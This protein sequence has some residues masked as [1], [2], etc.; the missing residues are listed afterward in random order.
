MAD[1]L[2][3]T[4]M[5]LD[6]EVKYAVF[7]GK[8]NS[9][10]G[11]DG[12]NFHFYKSAWQVI[13]LVVIRAV[14]SFFQKCYMP[15][16]VKATALAIVP[17]HK[18]ASNISEYR[19]I[20]LCNVFYKII[21]KVL[22]ER[23]KPV[24]NAIVKDN[25][26]G[27]VK[28][29]VSTD[30]ILL[31]NDI[32]FYAGKK[33]G[34][35]YF[36]A[37]LDIKKA[38]DSVSRDF[39]LERMLQKG[40]PSLF[41]NWIKSCISNVNYSILLNGTLEGYFSSSAGLR[42]GC[43][44]SPYL[45]CIVMDAFSNL[46]EYRGFRG[47]SHKEYSLSHLLY[48]DDVLI[49]GEASSE[50]CNILASILMDFANATGLNINYDKCSIMFPRNLRNAQEVCQ[51]LSIHN[52]VNNITYLGIPLSFYRLKIADF[53]PLMDSVSKK[54]NGWKACLL[55]FAGRMQYIKFT[56]QNTIAYWIRGSIMPKT[57]HKF[58]KR[59]SSKFL[60]F[61]DNMEVK[62][63]HMV[64]WDKICLPKNKGGLGIPSI[65]AL[66]YAY[67]CSV[68]YRMYNVSSPLSNWLLCVYKSPWMAPP[69]AASKIWKSICK[70][71]LAVKHCFTFNITR[72]APISLKYD[73]WCRN[74]TITEFLGGSFQGYCPDITLNTLICGNQWVFPDSI[75]ASL[76]SIIEGF[77]IPATDG[78]CLLWK[79]TNSYKFKSF[80][81][82][83][84]SDYQTCCW[85]KAIWP[86]K[87]ISKH[88]VFA[89]L[90]LVRGL[91]TA[92]ALIYRNINVPARCSLCYAFNE[93]INH[94][95][96]ECDYVFAVLTAVIPGLKSFLFRPSIMQVFEWIKGKHS[97]NKR[98]KHFFYMIICCVIYH[99]WKERNGRRFGNASICHATLSMNV[100]RNISDR[101]IGWKNYWSYLEL[102]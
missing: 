87:C 33:R 92:D 32:L 6:D 64:A 20:A 24:M 26:A 38:F 52:I 95:F 13:A 30:N 102:L 21:A 40:F 49:F 48:A 51:A 86:K 80:I 12:Y 57:V 23:M 100:R 89:W 68:I 82:E 61:G 50:N 65:S 17:K 10:P 53:L 81:D 42:Q 14:K 58:I 77:N 46:L 97:G 59:S 29:R 75:P 35:K 4:T 18:Y 60:F 88:S 101:I 70:T 15:N 45:F 44:L 78:N 63:L 31:A 43:P 74:H 91:K 5:V 9:A 54:M 27:F 1:A 39:L 90:A 22:A 62:K 99:T 7:S 25:Q 2:C 96:F 79:N 19:P 98:V 8:S 72:S 69:A 71:A 56:I 83:F 55:S 34:G 3:L 93:S 47:I 28:S 37:K 66:Q 16:G 73:H 94:L 11:P 84:Y 41:V 76:R 67:N 36:C 85:H